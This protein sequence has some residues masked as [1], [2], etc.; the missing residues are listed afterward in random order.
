[1]I[2]DSVQPAQQPQSVETSFSACGKVDPVRF[3]SFTCAPQ[4]IPSSGIDLL[5][6]G[7]IPSI[8]TEQLLLLEIEEMNGQLRM[9][10]ELANDPKSSQID[11]T[12]LLHSV[13]EARDRCAALEHEL[14]KTKRYDSLHAL[15]EPPRERSQSQALLPNRQSVGLDLVRMDWELHL[16]LEL[17]VSTPQKSVTLESPT[18]MTWSNRRV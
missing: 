10:K 18:P 11:C 9:L 3:E 16:P 12:F 4:L 1:M 5:G 8:P 15:A 6:A 17:T 7:F 14:A 13:Q 2:G